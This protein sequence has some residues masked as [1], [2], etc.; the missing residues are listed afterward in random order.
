LRLVTLAVSAKIKANHLQP[1]AIQG[2]DPAEI[3]VVV[4]EAYGA[5]VDEN[6]RVSAPV[7]FVVNAD[8]AVLN[9]GHDE[10]LGDEAGSMI[11]S[12]LVT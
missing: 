6:N 12:G 7:N 11:S 1:N 9:C 5:S 10:L 4:L 8:T 3:R 2:F